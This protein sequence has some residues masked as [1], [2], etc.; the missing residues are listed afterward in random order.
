MFNFFCISVQDVMRI[1]N[2]IYIC[3]LPEKFLLM[4]VFLSLLLSGHLVF[5]LAF[6]SR[7][8]R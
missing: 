2:I 1:N 8:E 6:C 4:C 7:I 5:N 3:R